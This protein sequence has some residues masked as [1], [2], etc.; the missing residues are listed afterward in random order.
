MLNFKTLSILTT[1]A[2]CLFAVSAHAGEM[3]QKADTQATSA[4]EATALLINEPKTAVLAA[5]DRA[6]LIPVTDEKG[7]TFYNQVVDTDELPIS[8]SNVDVADTYT[9]EYNGR[10]YTNKIVAGS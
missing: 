2:V 8:D 3:T 5:S 9:F 7:Q 10:T 4:T 6:G 1:S